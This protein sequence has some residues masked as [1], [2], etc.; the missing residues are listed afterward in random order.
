MPL[1]SLDN[2]LDKLRFEPFLLSFTQLAAAET[3]HAVERCKAQELQACHCWF[4]SSLHAQIEMAAHALTAWT[5]KIPIWVS[6]HR[7]T[8]ASVSMQ[9]MSDLALTGHTVIQRAWL[10]WFYRKSDIIQRGVSFEEQVP[11]VTKKTWG[12]SQAQPT[13]LQKCYKS[14]SLKLWA[15]PSNCFSCFYSKNRSNLHQQET[16]KL[17][18]RHISVPLKRK[19]K[20]KR[21]LF[22]EAIILSALY[23]GQTFIIRYSNDDNVR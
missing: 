9:L 17:W 14:W 22:K 10:F 3:N 23:W 12:F 5:I 8:W 13:H 7:A 18:Q 2:W 16:N 21:T 6:Q 4:Y 19:K 11:F 20:K 15:E 1:L